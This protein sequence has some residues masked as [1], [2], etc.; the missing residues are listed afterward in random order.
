MD[1]NLLLRAESYLQLELLDQSHASELFAL[2]DGE[3]EYLKRWLPWLDNNKYLQNT[4]DF[5]AYSRKQ[6][7][8]SISLT[9][10]IV[11]RGKIAGVIGFHRVDWVNH[12][13]SIGY[14][15]GESYQGRGIITRSC[16]TLI[17]YGFGRLGFNR[18]EIRCATGN[19]KSRAVPERLGFF[20][21]G[22]LRAAEW[23]YD[24]Y[25]DHV[26]YAMLRADWNPSPAS[27]G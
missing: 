12:S 11:Y 17:D 8:E 19:T 10:A 5:V 18:I 27:H 2:I 14:W 26:V 9:M 15:L 21:E 7:A 22:T 13:T 16:R 20:E 25:V 6:F 4:V 1:D 3:R 23:L 24:H